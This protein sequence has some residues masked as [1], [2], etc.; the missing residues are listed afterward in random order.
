MKQTQ[1]AVCPQGHSIEQ[2]PSPQN[3][4]HSKGHAMSA[5]AS[6]INKQPPIASQTL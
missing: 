4:E 1:I 3:T 6:P 5:H 2:P